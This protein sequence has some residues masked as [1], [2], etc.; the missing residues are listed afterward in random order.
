[1]AMASAVRPHVVI[2]AFPSK[3][4]IV[5][6]MSFAKVLASAGLHL[7]FVSARYSISEIE[8]ELHAAEDQLPHIHCVGLPMPVEITYRN[9]LARDQ[10]STLLL[11]KEAFQK[12]SADFEQL[13]DKLVAGSLPDR[14]SLCGPPLAIISD[15]FCSWTQAVAIKFGIPRYVLYTSPAKLLAVQFY[16]PSLVAQGRLPEPDSTDEDSNAPA[17]E[18]IISI[19]AL[20]PVPLRE[21]P[22]SLKDSSPKIVHQ[23]FHSNACRLHETS[24]ILVNSFYELESNAIDALNEEILNPN[25]VSIFPI[26]PLLPYP[27]FVDDSQVVSSSSVET[28]KFT[29]WLDSQ[30]PLTVL[31]INFGSMYTPPRAQTYEIALGLEASQIPFFWVLP[32]ASISDRSKPS[33][34]FPQGFEQRTQKQGLVVSSW[35]KQPLILSHPSTGGFLTHCGWNSTL[36]SICSGVPMIA[37]PQFAEQELICTMVVDKWKVG[38]R[39]ESGTDGSVRGTDLEK[40]VKRL[41]EGSEEAAHIRQRVAEMRMAARRAIEQPDGS[42]ASYLQGFVREIQAKGVN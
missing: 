8:I 29:D 38:L 39:L 4:H 1:M 11:M 27:F 12:T 13:I 19:P 40:V 7:T 37:F 35:V 32:A 34:V 22:K 15:N 16:Y 21:L 24:G 10:E 20:G 3:G 18:D 5:P 6:A 42:S 28:N 25:R 23:F 2:A 17:V 26:G 36:E 31:Y 9:H 14:L 41:L 30:S 33:L